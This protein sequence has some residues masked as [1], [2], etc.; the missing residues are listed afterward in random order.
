[1]NQL[2]TPSISVMPAWLDNSLVSAKHLTLPDRHNKTQKQWYYEQPKDKQSWEQLYTG[3]R[4]EQEQLRSLPLI[5]IVGAI[6]EVANQWLD[7][8]WSMRVDTVE[9]IEA[10]TG[11]STEVI[12]RCLDVELRNYQ[13]DSLWRTLKRE[14]KDPFVLDTFCNNKEL[15]G[16]AMAIGP[17]ATLTIFTGNVPALPALS[18]VRCLLVKSAVVAK[19]ASG[20]PSFASQ[21]AT[22]ISEINPILGNAI[23]VTYWDRDDHSSLYN[24][25]HNADAVIAYG[26]LNACAA[27]REAIQPEQTYIEHGHKYSIGIITKDYLNQ[28]GVDRV[29]TAIADDV[30]TFNQHACIAPQA[31]FMQLNETELAEFSQALGGKFNEFNEQYPIGSFSDSEACNIQLSRIKESWGASTAKLNTHLQSDDLGWTINIRDSLPESRI[32]GNR[33]LDLVGYNN[34]QEVINTLKPF[35]HF[36]QNIAIGDHSDHFLKTA[37]QFAQMGACRICAPGKMSIPSLIWNH[38]GI[39]CI[40]RL[41]RWCDI[42]MTN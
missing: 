13:S 17:Q 38:D 10:A 14:L 32:S 33:V 11:F 22:S 41:L 16:S 36:L 4:N 19:V 39:P 21:F 27:V 5:T 3:L 31:Y 28:V 1:M 18:I 40:E 8:N 42:E 29:T 25:V 37:T 34:T 23:A 6:S 15:E 24:A 12:N 26:G 2:E 35:S 7:R 30:F 20:E 9:R